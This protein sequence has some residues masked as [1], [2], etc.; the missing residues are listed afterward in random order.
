MACTLC[1]DVAGYSLAI[2]NIS[3][4]PG[5]GEPQ[6]TNFNACADAANAGIPQ[7]K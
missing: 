3:L 6:T 2:I 4:R 7:P 5:S 1:Y